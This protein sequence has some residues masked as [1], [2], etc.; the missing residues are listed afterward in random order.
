M[1]QFAIST[2]CQFQ[3]SPFESE[4]IISKKFGKLQFALIIPR[5]G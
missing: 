4:E 1:C 3:I 2:I 5:P